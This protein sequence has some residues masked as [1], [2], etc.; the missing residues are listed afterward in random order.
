MEKNIK[1]AMQRQILSTEL[2][3]DNALLVLSKKRHFPYT[4]LSVCYIEEG[5]NSLVEDRICLYENASRIEYNDRMVA[6]FSLDVTKP[7]QVYD[8]EH[9]E[10]ATG[11]FLTTVYN[12]RISSKV[13]V[14]KAK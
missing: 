4:I 1:E 14:Y 3:N 13:F 2:L 10:F 9:K 7:F 5:K 12:S 6:V 8:L 11:D